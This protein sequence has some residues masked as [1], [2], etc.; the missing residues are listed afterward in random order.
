MHA[1]HAE[2]VCVSTP[3]L[4]AKSFSSLAGL[5]LLSFF[6]PYIRGFLILPLYMML[7]LRFLPRLRVQTFDVFFALLLCMFFVWKLQF[8]NAFDC[9][10]IFRVFFGYFLF[11]LVFR[12]YNLMSELNFNTAA[13]CLSLSV[14]IEAVLVNTVLDPAHL[15]VY[16]NFATSTGRTALYGF[17]QRPYGIG[18][19]ASV[20]SVLIVVTLCLARLQKQ[21]FKPSLLTE[22]V[23]FVAILSFFS[24]AGFVSYGVYI[25]SRFLKSAFTFFLNPVSIFIGL[26]VFLPELF[27]DVSILTKFS[28]SYLSYLLQFKEAQLQFVMETLERS[29]DFH[30]L[31][32]GFLKGGEGTYGGDFGWVDLFSST[33]LVGFFLFLWFFFKKINSVNAVPLFVFFLASFHYSAAISG[34]GQILLGL[35]FALDSHSLKHG[36]Y[37]GI[38]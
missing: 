24:G 25:L 12:S 31:Y 36:A 33:G 32:F 37:C 28:G 21:Y 1:N 16:P 27:M 23:A 14:L 26:L 29:P 5:V 8:L 10:Q 34:V 9:F 2:E 7:M 4:G 6:L 20:T 22:F 17:Y 30:D 15:A 11:Y 35:C 13:L 19:S 38:S 18:S 3:S